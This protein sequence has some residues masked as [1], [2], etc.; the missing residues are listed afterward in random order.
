MAMNA[1]RIDRYCAR[2][3]A[4]WKTVPDWRFGQLMCNLLGAAGVDPFFPED[5]ELFTAMEHEMSE[6]FRPGEF[7]NNH[8]EGVLRNEQS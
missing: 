3:A 1:S 2:L 7:V 5:E 8:I 6:R 4:L